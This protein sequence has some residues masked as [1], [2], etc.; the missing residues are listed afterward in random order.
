MTHT[1]HQL[2]GHTQIR[3]EFPSY[4][5]TLSL[6]NSELPK[7]RGE[8]EYD[9]WMAMENIINNQ[10]NTISM[11][12]SAHGLL[13]IAEP[14]SAKAKELLHQVLQTKRL[15][16]STRNILRRTYELEDS[17][18]PDFCGDNWET[19]VKA[20]MVRD[21][22]ARLLELNKLQLAKLILEDELLEP[23]DSIH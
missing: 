23:G 15:R 14:P 7:Y 2:L 9:A 11:L 20:A 22:S 18:I 13:S 1:F 16:T 21:Y 4:Y 10:L 19:D 12:R 3:Y 5:I 17:T 6:K 8:D